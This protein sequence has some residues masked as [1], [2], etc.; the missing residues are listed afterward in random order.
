MF[1][2]L[3]RHVTS[4]FNF[5]K[6]ALKGC[7]WK[8]QSDGGSDNVVNCGK[9]EVVCVKLGYKISAANC[10]NSQNMAL[11]LEWDRSV[12]EL[13]YLGDSDFLC[14]KDRKWSAYILTDRIKGGNYPNS[15]SKR[16]NWS[17]QTQPKAING[18]DAVELHGS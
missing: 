18:F 5:S 12:N 7:L 17:W 1:K 4:G 15:K 13:S 16:L 3:D 8:I 6:D 9:S 14:R 10:S 11:S 2:L